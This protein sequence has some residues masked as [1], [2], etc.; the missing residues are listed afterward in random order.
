VEIIECGY[1][2]AETGQVQQLRTTYE[3]PDML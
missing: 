2:A 1:K 3:P